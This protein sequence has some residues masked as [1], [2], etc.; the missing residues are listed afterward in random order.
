MSRLKTLQG[1]LQ[2]SLEKEAKNVKKVKDEGQLIQGIVLGR[3]VAY[4]NILKVIDNML[5]DEEVNNG[6]D[7]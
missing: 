4:L 5:Y 1:Y 3:S 7:R 2:D 6:S